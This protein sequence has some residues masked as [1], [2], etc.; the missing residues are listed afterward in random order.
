MV[1]GLAKR[2]A[3]DQGG[4]AFSQRSRRLAVAALVLRHAERE[5]LTLSLSK[6]EARGAIAGARGI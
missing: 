6:G 3:R 1:L 2:G 4:G 5:D